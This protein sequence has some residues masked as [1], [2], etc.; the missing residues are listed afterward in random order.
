MT[1]LE[2]GPGSPSQGPAGAPPR[3]SSRNRPV[4]RGRTSLP[5]GAQVVYR[6]GRSIPRLKR[7]DLE[8]TLLDFHANPVIQYECRTALENAERYLLAQHRPRKGHHYV[9]AR[10]IP[11]GMRLAFYSGLVE[12]ADVRHARDHEMHMGEIGLG[13]EVT[14]DGTPGL[15]PEDDLRPGRLQIINHCCRPGNNC[16]V[17]AVVCEVTF[18]TLYVLVSNTDIDAGIELTF[19]YQ[20]PRLVNGV[21]SIARGAFWQNAATITVIP[22]GMR[23]VRCQC[24]SKCPNGW[25]RL[26]RDVTHPPPRAPH[27]HPTPPPQ[28]FYHIPIHLS[29]LHIYTHPHLQPHLHPHPHPTRPLHPLQAPPLLQL[30]PTPPTLPPPPRPPPLPIHPLPLHPH[31]P[32]HPHESIRHLPPTPA[33]LTTHTQTHTRTPPLLQS[34]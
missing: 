4:K 2:G 10:N 23:V 29:L 11:A 13:F 19:P 26:E 9:A 5:A 31:P 28:H 27:P 1:G 3:R 7:D 24:Q 18:V 14:I 25:G 34:M 33:P 20:E 32:T 16:D 8:D 30:T 22:R 6:V 12:R 17:V 21:P 15:V